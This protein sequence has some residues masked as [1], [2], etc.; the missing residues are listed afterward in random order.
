MGLRWYSGLGG[1]MPPGQAP[2]ASDVIDIEYFSRRGCQSMV[3]VRHSAGRL[4]AR[5][6]AGLLDD[7]AG[8]LPT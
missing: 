4:H 2:I 3:I 1:S 6:R 7:D 8:L 5:Q